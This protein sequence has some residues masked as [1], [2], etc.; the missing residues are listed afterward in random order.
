MNK[1]RTLFMCKSTCVKTDPPDFTF[2]AHFGI[3]VKSCSRTGVNGM[4][5]PGTA[6]LEFALTCLQ[7]SCDYYSRGT[8]T[9]A[10]EHTMKSDDMSGILHAASLSLDLH[11][12]GYKQ[13]LRVRLAEVATCNKLWSLLER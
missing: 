13:F 9:R 8:N 11:A 7:A 6:R 12:Q 1:T 5:G 2:K 4:L 10:Y 3:R